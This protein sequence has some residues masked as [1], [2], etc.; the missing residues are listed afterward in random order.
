MK[1]YLLLFILAAQFAVISNATI[2]VVQVV[3]FQFNP[4]N[5]TDVFVG[6]I[7]RFEFAHGFHN[8]V[9]NGIPNGI[10]ASAA[11]INSGG[12]SGAVRTYD[13]NVTEAGN[14]KYVCEQHG[15]A[16]T[17][18]GMKGE[19]TAAIVTP[20]KLTLFNVNNSNEI[21]FL[22][23]KTQNEENVDYFSV[24]RS[25]NGADY[26]EVAKVQATGLPGFE[27]SY[28]F[29]DSKISMVNKYYY[30]KLAVVDKDGK[31]TFSETRLFKNL[32][33]TSKLV[34][35]LSPNPISAPG[36]LMIRFNADKEGKMELKLID[37]QGKAVA[38]SVMQ[39]YEGVNNGHFHLGNLAPGSYT[40]ICTLNGI[41]ET[42][43]ILAK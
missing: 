7:V 15:D 35:S 30:Y 12:V 33:A 24:Q 42:H 20:L 3:N 31:Q 9:S 32:K 11:P 4:S 22:K 1:K 5:I 25:V 19:F 43:R 23:W 2:H 13:Y 34:M 8:A 10:P 18:T 38:A 26:T 40:L 27:T 6:D 21:P 36:H 14:Y 39:A 41:R 28:S 16:A 37:G 17:Y 29:S